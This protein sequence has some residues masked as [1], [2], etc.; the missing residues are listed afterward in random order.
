MTTRVQTTRTRTTTKTRTDENEY[1]E[2]ED[3]DD[4]DEDDKHKDDDHEDDKHRLFLASTTVLYNYGHSC[5][6]EK[7]KARHGHGKTKSMAR[8]RPVAGKLPARQW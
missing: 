8:S 5:K 1:E 3:L 7:L 2:H 6:I 4:E